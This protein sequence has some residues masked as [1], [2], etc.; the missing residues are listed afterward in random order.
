MPFDSDSTYY[1]KAQAGSAYIISELYEIAAG[2][3]QNIHL[4]N[5]ENSGK[6]FWVMN[7]TVSSDGPYTAEIH[8]TFNAAPSG[9]SD[10]QIQNV[11]L[12]SEGDINEGTGVANASVDFDASG[13]HAVGVGGGGAGGNASGSLIT[14]P[15]VVIQEKREIVLQAENTGSGANNYGLMIL[16]HEKPEN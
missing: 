15:P 7:A 11:L 6:Q 4:K 8:D 13:T 1:R 12:D 5:P 2:A 16:Y 14:H 9:G 3:T 10:L